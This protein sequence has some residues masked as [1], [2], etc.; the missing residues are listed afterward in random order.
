MNTIAVDLLA[1]VGFEKVISTANSLGI[2]YKEQLGH[3]Y[4][5]AIGAFEETVL[6][7]TAAYAGIA[8]RGIYIQPSAIEEIRGADNKVIWSHKTNGDK[9]NRAIDEDVA[10]IMNWMLRK[11]VSEGSGM[12]ASFK[13]RQVAGK[14]GTSEGNRDL[15]FI[16]SIPQ[17]TTSVWFGKDNNEENKA[18]SGDAAYAWKQF[19][20]K[21]EI[22]LEVL[23]FPERPFL[24][25]D[26]RENL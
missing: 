6:N 19:I 1:K 21:I 12:A 10:D 20:Q 14:T 24:K 11:V 16:G 8:N 23:T 15:W 13:G 9:G 2:G 22:D 7:M 26:Q 3:Y 5:L 25:G 18:S 17:L 4:P